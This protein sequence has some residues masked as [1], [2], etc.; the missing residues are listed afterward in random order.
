M[1]TQNL[2]RLLR[3]KR[4][5]SYLSGIIALLLVSFVPALEGQEEQLI[6]AI[7][8]LTLMLIGSYGVQDAATAWKTSSSINIVNRDSGVGV[9]E[10]LARTP[11]I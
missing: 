7:R 6:D 11:N 5:W 9:A 2:P 10:A 1:N 8:N 4:F 3:S